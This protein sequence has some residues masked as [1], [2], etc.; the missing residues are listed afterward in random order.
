MKNKYIILSALVLITGSVVAGYNINREKKAGNTNQTNQV[1]KNTKTGFKEDWKN[2]K[3]DANLKIKANE[4]SIAEFK[5]KIKKEDKVLKAK[6]KKEVAV[7]EQKNVELKK[8]L[9]EFKFES[10][11][12]WE[13]FKLGFNH[14][15]DVVGKS[16]KDFFTTKD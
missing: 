6:Y 13:E 12:K 9:R 3:V 15:M 1:L 7:L 4:K 16:I 5:I 10:E 14:D 2:F 11:D 8:K